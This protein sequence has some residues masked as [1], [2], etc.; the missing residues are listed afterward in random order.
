[1]LVIYSASWCRFCKK[2]KDELETFN[3]P[4]KEVDIDKEVDLA[5]TLIDKRLKTIPQVFTEDGKHIGG[6]DDTIAY[7]HAMK[8]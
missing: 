6:C 3:I 7:I 8:G 5:M 2:L 1:M 4:F